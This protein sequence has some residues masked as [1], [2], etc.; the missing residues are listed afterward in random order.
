MATLD[1]LQAQLAA[2]TQ[3]VDEITAP[4][5]DYYT[6]RFSGEEIDNAVGR[7]ADTPGSGAITAGDIGAAPSGFGFGD[8][9][10]GFF[11]NSG[12]EQPGLDYLKSLLDGM[13][14]GTF[15]C[16]T[17]ND[18]YTLGVLGT[19]RTIH[20]KLYKFAS[21]NAL[22]EFRTTNSVG[23]TIIG[24]RGYGDAGWKPIEL[25]N[26]LMSLGVEYRTTERYKEKP[27]YVKLVNFGN[28]PNETNMGVAHNSENVLDVICGFLKNQDGT[29]LND[30][31]LIENFTVGRTFIGIKTSGDMSSN[32][33]T[34]LMKYT[35]TT[36]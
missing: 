11:N 2:L 34:V 3:R 8:N 32:I 29:I 5:D 14:N 7:V 24:Y 26:P 19:T 30:Y 4:P 21:T 10:N 15:K 9:S 28:L 35:K 18:Y 1:E 31:Y 22:A 20:C 16:F 17:F 12:E 13:P 33:G 36:D 25:L 6:H 23:V 27:V